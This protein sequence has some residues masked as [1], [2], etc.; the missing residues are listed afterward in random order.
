M[1]RSSVGII[2]ILLALG[3]MNFWVR[4]LWVSIGISSQEEAALETALSRF[5]ELKEYRDTLLETYNSIGQEDLER[6]K[7]FLPQSEKAGLLLVNLE[8][9]GK[10]SGVLMK[11]IDVQ[12]QR[13]KEEVMAS[14]EVE[15]L[16]FSLSFSAP[17]APFRSFLAALEGHR[18]LIEIE[19]ISFPVPVR[20]TD[21]YEFSIQAHTYWQQ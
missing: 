18:R 21:S 9:L 11:N 2:L 8:N 17:Y 19:R 12:S 4:P 14:G 10:S 5:R 7:E 6:L 13:G 15:R 20:E 16:P 3:I 1:I